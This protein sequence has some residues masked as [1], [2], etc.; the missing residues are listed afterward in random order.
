V[1]VAARFREADELPKNY[2]RDRSGLCDLIPRT[3]DAACSE[4][5]QLLKL[6]F[7]QKEGRGYSCFA[8]VS[9]RDSRWFFFAYPEDF[10]RSYIEYDGHDD[11]P[12]RRVHRPAFQ[13]VFVYDPGNGSLSTYFQGSAAAAHDLEHLFARA[14]L[15]VDLPSPARD[16]RVYELNPFKYRG[17][18]FRYDAASGIADVRVRQLRL[19]LLGGGSR[20]VTIDADPTGGSGAI[21]D[22]LDSA[23][24]TGAGSPRTNRIHLSL[25]NVTRVGIKAYFAH[26]GRGRRPTKTFYISFPNSCTLKHEGRDAVLRKMLIDSDI[27][28]RIGQNFRPTG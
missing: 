1:E 21:Y 7:R 12:Q 15:A 28:P 4:L 11:R 13:V 17:F 18:P 19:S 5:A 24:E 22:L 23:T 2:W 25:V 27:E 9:H 10:G 6:Y 20:R 3:D 16:E 8:E 14:I 26:D